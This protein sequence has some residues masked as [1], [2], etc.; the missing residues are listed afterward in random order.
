LFV[1]EDAAAALTMG[2]IGIEDESGLKAH[3]DSRGAEDD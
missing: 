3:P 1:Q 2:F